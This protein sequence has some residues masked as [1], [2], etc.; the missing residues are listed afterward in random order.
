MRE[1][2]VSILNSLSWTIQPKMGLVKGE[3]YREEGWF[4]P[5]PGDSKDFY[6]VLEAVCEDGNLQM[7]EFNE[8]NAPTYYIRK[9]QNASKRYSDYAFLQ[10]SRERT[11]ST[12]V[13]LVNGMTYVEGQ[14]MRENRLNG[15]FDLLTGASNSI[16]ESMLV[17]AEKISERLNTPSKQ[18]YYGLAMAVEPGITG[19]L[20]VVMEKGK[21][22]SCFYDEIFADHPEEIEN[23]ELKP[24]YRQSKY[25]SLDYVSD[26]P[27]G[28]NALFDMWRKHALECQNLLDLSGLR[29]SQGE[30][31]GR[32]WGNYLKVA[33]ELWKELQKDGAFVDKGAGK[34]A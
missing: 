22:V 32:A 28:F 14:M 9:Y 13:V 6:G 5:H 31:S 34:G 30:F 20:Q 16:R 24:Y 27:C 2:T 12:H 23:P 7:V 15:P 11:A 33:G 21:M 4:T 18:Y 10:A 17:L 29:F 8:F 25:Y 19:R 3:Y 26:Y 1:K